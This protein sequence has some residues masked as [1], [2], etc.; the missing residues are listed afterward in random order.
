MVVMRRMATVQW[1]TP[2]WR[3]HDSVSNP[4]VDA[5]MVRGGFEGDYTPVGI[6]TTDVIGPQDSL[7]QLGDRASQRFAAQ[8]GG[9]Q[10][11][12][13]TQ[14]EAGAHAPGL[15]QMLTADLTVDGR[16]YALRHLDGFVGT[17]QQDGS[18]AVVGISV[19]CTADQLDVVGPEFGAVL[20]SISPS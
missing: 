6:V 10:R 17:R 7:E 5:T 19:T 13:R 8:T 12:R 18:V 16:T 1:P 14:T 3:R 15:S 9:A 4:G 2:Q 11:I 20:T